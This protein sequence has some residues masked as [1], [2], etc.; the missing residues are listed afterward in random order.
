[1]A[2]RVLFIAHA[3]DANKDKHHSVI[4]TEKF[5]LYAVVVKNQKE[6]LEISKEY[7]EEKKIDSIILCPGFRHED[8]AEL[9]GAAK[10]KVGVSVAR[11][12]GL[13]NQISREAMKR[14][15]YF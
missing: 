8:V 13:S 5:I 10:G 6:A 15:G 11:G 3:P 1:M 4:Q 12:D 9:Y 2:F 7:I 14:E